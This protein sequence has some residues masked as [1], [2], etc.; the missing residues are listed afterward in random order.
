MVGMV[1]PVADVL[2][3]VADI[4]GRIG[5]LLVELLNHPDTVETAEQLRRLGGHV[6]SLSAELLARA[7]E[8]DG[9]AVEPPGRVVIGARVES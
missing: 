3:R 5:P 7:A 4:T 9:R 8:L 6:G 2:T 1:E